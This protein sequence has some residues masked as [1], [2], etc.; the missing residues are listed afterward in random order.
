MRPFLVI[1][2]DK[3]TDGGA[4]V[5]F[6]ERHHPRQT[7]GSD[8]P[9]KALRKRV[10]IRTPGRQ[11]HERHATVLQQVPKGG[12]VQR[13]SV[14]NQVVRVAEEAIVRIGQVA[15]HL[16]HPWFVWL[17]RDAGDLHG[18]GLELHDEEDDVADQSSPSQ[19]LDGEKVRGREPSQ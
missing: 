15:S 12:R 2:I 5:R 9:D 6:A 18:A 19:H 14:E 11:A 17:T 4:E 13:I 8:R 1:V 10:Q 16:C 7:L 3:R